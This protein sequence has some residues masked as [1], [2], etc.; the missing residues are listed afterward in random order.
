MKIVPL[1]TNS[2]VTFGLQ[3]IHGRFDILSRD[4]VILHVGISKGEALNLGALLIFGHCVAPGGLDQK[5][6]FVRH[7]ISPLRD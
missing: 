1:G 7:F 2:G 6:E 5:F 3:G 4:T